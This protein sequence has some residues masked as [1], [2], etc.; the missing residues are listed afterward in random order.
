[1]GKF[2]LINYKIMKLAIIALLGTSAAIQHSTRWE[3][4]QNSRANRWQ[5]YQMAQ[6]RNEPYSNELSNGDVSD[7]KQLEDVD[8][9]KYDVAD[10]VGF[11]N[12]W[13]HTGNVAQQRRVRF[14]QMR[15]TPGEPYSNELSNG[16]ESD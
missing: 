6:M 5:R 8:N 16:D 15:D 14:N 11:T 4:Y 10:D 2:I 12:V 3:R 9:A 1:M 7:D 13:K